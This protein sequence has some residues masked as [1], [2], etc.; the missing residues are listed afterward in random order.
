M[1]FPPANQVAM[2][3]QSFMKATNSCTY[4]PHPVHT[5]GS[6]KHYHSF[7]NLKYRPANDHI[8]C[9]HQPCKNVI[10]KRDSLLAND[11]LL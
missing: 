6:K 3:V 5:Q 10:F 9:C 8:K 1:C 4:N 2:R 11:L 7:L